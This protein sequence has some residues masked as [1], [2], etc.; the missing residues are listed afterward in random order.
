ME[1]IDFGVRERPSIYKPPKIVQPEEIMTIS[2][3]D[4]HEFVPKVET[5]PIKKPQF[6]NKGN[7][8]QDFNPWTQTVPTQI[9]SC[10]SL[11]KLYSLFYHR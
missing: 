6:I 7:L 8:Y 2:E 3:K 4:G 1:S 10:L 9:V 5:E 11:S